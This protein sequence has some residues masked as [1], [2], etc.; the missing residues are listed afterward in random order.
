DKK[1]FEK[2]CDDFREASHL[3]PRAPEPKAKLAM[4]LVALRHGGPTARPIPVDTYDASEPPPEKAT[5]SNDLGYLLETGY[6]K[7][8]EGKTREALDRLGRAVRLFPNDPRA[9]RYLG[10][11]LLQAHQPL[12]ATEQ[13]RK[14]ST[15]GG[16][17]VEDKLG[18]A[19][20]LQ[21]S[22]RANEAIK[23]YN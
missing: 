19:E 12:G 6:R 17:T 7:L 21:T 9:R 13:F 16:L 4:A 15:L 1:D 20:A 11:A 23:T 3:N 18:L 8:T 22:G 10:Y 14:L 5:T 2:A